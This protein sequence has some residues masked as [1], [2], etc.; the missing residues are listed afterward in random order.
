M[1]VGEVFCLSLDKN[2][3][4]T[5]NSY[6]YRLQNQYQTDKWICGQIPKILS[7]IHSLIT[8]HC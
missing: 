6:D 7:D 8:E 1:R 5:V 3:Q 4:L 2:I